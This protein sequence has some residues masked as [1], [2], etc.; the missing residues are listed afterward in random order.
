[1]EHIG[2]DAAKRRNTTSRDVIGPAIAEQQD[3]GNL[4][5]AKEIVEEHRPIAETTAEVGCCFGPVDAVA[6]TD[7]DPLHLHALLAH[8]DR[9]LMH[10]RPRRTLQEK[11][12]TFCG[13]LDWRAWTDRRRRR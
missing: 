1:F 10:H 13:P 3:V 7:I 2:A 5:F 4:M 8:R 12:G 6:S 9:E 11:E